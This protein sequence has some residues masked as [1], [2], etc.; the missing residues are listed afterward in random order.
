VTT[1]TTRFD[2]G[3]RMPFLALLA[4]EIRRFRARRVVEMG[5]ATALGIAILVIV[6]ATVRST[7][8]VAGP[9]VSDHTMRLVELWRVARGSIQHEAVL[10]VSAYV[11]ILVVGIAATGVG[12][13][14][15]SGTI[16]TLLTWEPRRVRVAL[17][18]IIAIV[19]VSVVIY[20][21]V[22][23][24]FIGGW[25]LGASWR[26]S[27]AGLGPDFWIDLVAVV[28]RGVAAIAV[29][30]AITAGLA[31]LTRSTVGAVMVW[32]AYLI[33]IEAVLGQRVRSLQP[34]LLFGN[35]VAFLE[36]IDARFPDEVGGDGSLLQRVS[37]PGP[38]LVRI[39]VIAAAVVALG[40]AVFARRDV[41]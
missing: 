27:T 34:G 29:L 19:L 4:S 6:V 30:A 21:V 36:G 39:L 24:V 35:L 23:G 12:A 20:V 14:Y 3:T 40:V 8:A 13:E 11:F 17:A 16:G 7:G 31:F 9:G 22:I 25:A 1:A 18:R 37:Q 38:G 28:A 32:F 10:S 2:R 15:R 33:G 5:F 41:T 26:G